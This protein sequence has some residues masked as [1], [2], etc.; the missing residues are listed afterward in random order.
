[1]E[2]PM[3]INPQM[4]E[5]INFAMQQ[6][7][8]PVFRSLTLTNNTEDPLK[9]IK[10]SITFEPEF[11]KPWETSVDLLESGKPVEISPVRIVMLSEYLYSLTEK[12]S[13]NVHIQAK[14]GD[15]TVF[16]EDKSIELYACDQWL[17]IHILPEMTAAFITPNHPKISEITA[18]ASMY[19]NKW[20]GDPSFTG[21]QT[22][23]PNIVKKQAAA[24]YAALQ[25]ENIAYTMPPASY[26]IRGQRV[27]L[28]YDVLEQKCGTCIDLS[29]LFAACCENVGLSPLIIFLKNHAFA[30]VWLEDETFSE[31]CEDDLA[32]LTKRTADGINALCLIECTDFTAGRSVEFDLSVKHAN[33]N[34]HDADKFEF[35]LDIVRC[36]VSGIRPMPV[37]IMQN[38]VFTSIDH[39]ERGQNDITNAPKDLG[40]TFEIKEG[41]KEITRQDIWER[42]L[43]DINLKNNLL[44]FRPSSSNI[45]FMT[46]SLSDLEDHI[47]C[48]EDLK[49]MPAPQEMTLQISDSK[50]FEIE[51]EKDLITSIADAE[52]KNKRLRTFISPAELDRILKKLHRQAK[53]SLEENGANTLYL[54]LGLLRWY[55][56]PRSERPRYAPIVLIPVDMI[57]KV[58]DRSYS[59]RIRDEE[60]QIN[61]TLL[62]M[63]RQ[64]FGINISGLDPLPLDES[65]VDLPMIFSTIRSCVMPQKRWDIVETAFL[66]QFSFSHFIM[67]ND[68]RSR[69]KE[70]AQNK[71]VASIISGKLEWQPKNIEMTCAQMDEEISPADMAVPMSVDSS[72][73]AAIYAAAQGESFVLHGPPGTGKSQTITNMIANALYNGKTVL[74]VAEK[75]AALSVVQKRLASIGIDPFCLELH[76]NKTQK[77]AVLG[78]LEQALAAGRIKAPEDHERTAA[79]LYKL[80]KELN[81]VMTRIHRVS[82]IGMSLYDAVVRYDALVEHKS[83]IIIP[84]QN[85]SQLDKYK[86][87][88]ILDILKNISAVGRECGGYKNSP[89]KNY[90]RKDHSPEIKDNFEKITKEFLNIIPQI[91]SYFSELSTYFDTSFSQYYDD[92]FAAVKILSSAANGEYFAQAIS[93]QNIFSLKNEIDQ[94]LDSGKKFAAISEEISKDFEDTVFNIDAVQLKLEWKRCEQKWLIPK[95][96]GKKKIVKE[97]NIHSCENGTVT[98]DNFLQICGKLENYAKLKE[99]INC[100]DE[101]IISIFG[102]MWQ[103]ENSQFELIEKNILRS[104][105]IKNMLDTL[106]H[107]REEIMIALISMADNADKKAEISKKL[108]EYYPVYTNLENILDELENKY[109]I[110]LENIKNSQCWFDTAQKEADGWIDSIAF[111][112]ERSTLENLI[113]ELKELAPE[114]AQAYISGQ[115]TEEDILPAFEFA[116]SS[117]FISDVFANDP[118]LA[119]FQSTSFDGKLEK[120]RELTER[121]RQLTINELAA[122]LSAKIPDASTETSSST[123][124]LSLLRKAVKNGGR[125][126]PI[127]KLFDSIPNLLR[128]ICP[129]MLMSPI[130]VAQYIDPSFPKF[131][132]VIFDEASQMPTA[133]AVGAIARG[134]NVIVVGDPKQMPPTSFFASNQVDEENYDKE[135]LESVLD[136]CLAL[137][138]PERHLLWHYRSRHESL[139]AFSN[140]KFYGNDLLTFP[141]PSDNISEVKWVNVDGYYDKGKTKQNRAEAAAIVSEIVRRLKD[142]RLRQESIGVVTFSL[143]QQNLIDDMLSE[144]FV[145]DPQLE[146]YADE[147]YEPIFIKNLENVQGDERDVILFSIGYGPDENG[148]VSMN[149]GPLNRDGGWRRLNVAVSRARKEMIV[150]SVIRPEQIDLSRTRSDGVA[151]LRS[152]IEYAAKGKTALAVNS[153]NRSGYS[154]G[155]AKAIAEELRKHGCK[156][157]CGIGC[158]G[159]K[160]DVGIFDPEDPSRYLLALMCDSRS[161]IDN[162]TSRDRNIVQ[163]EILKGLG[164]NICNVHILDWL[165][166]K[167]RVIEKI[168]SAINEAS[169]KRKNSSAEIIPETAVKNAPIIFEHTEAPTDRPKGEIYV[170]CELPVMGTAEK[171]YEPTELNKI[172]DCIKK[173]VN[174]EAPISS[175]NVE[176]KIISAWGISRSGSRVSKVIENA[177]RICGIKTTV[178]N[179]SVFL[180]ADGQEPDEYHGCRI[181]YD[182]QKRSMDDICA[183]EICEGIMIILRAQIGMSK[184]DLIRE[185]AK[186]FGFTR[187]GG[188]IESSVNSG[189]DHAVKNGLI[190]IDD[191]DKITIREQ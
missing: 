119:S 3:T 115:V 101:N 112:R 14:C 57:R 15:E 68:I 145:K 136:D 63:L 38:G 188:V 156:A 86:Y 93:S 12:I 28:P 165:N 60:T 66:G 109:F 26:E 105:E 142:E 128:R 71:V 98:Q 21:Y 9:D 185:T 90:H 118:E 99:K 148:K 39:G 37:R 27:R 95:I 174:K 77:K 184:S 173:V 87:E 113:C 48:G 17:G 20:T 163:P 132:L 4:T 151:Y 139:I 141:S 53:V 172:I 171:F 134:E 33:H 164:W 144:E 29:L 83:K 44:N 111:L 18:K 138:M 11:A 129:C 180:W 56:T 158:S 69:S 179:S 85:I 182:G 154:D 191:N 74:F 55:E 7:Y 159:Y 143:V 122:R 22:K 155:F 52:F 79:K 94:L 70:L 114:A 181:H 10:I 65:G 92:Y 73:L 131:D 187:I 190:D 167:Q 102:R 31:P 25:A 162:S 54:A 130:S 100:A 59:L 61:I 183:Q 120:Y 89:L 127:R 5:K 178:S 45:Q 72:Q 110:D 41:T 121:F 137:A 124:E 36:R 88:N 91:R 6:N 157:E 75:M 30:G 117:A 46:A 76:S 58:Q 81:S 107:G 147:N 96:L 84:A 116:A 35:A 50:I 106:S 123:S 126:L 2:Y 49:I 170:Y 135:D 1:M 153:E 175:K 149:F 125:M 133:E 16:A 146:I 177:V 169:Q 97:M 67:W 168:I 176:K 40:R 24:L 23:N 80:R 19:L 152:F 42:K 161:S 64:N 13:G 150:Y 8:I 103:K 82:S 108:A 32:A 160:I 78:Q 189:I 140:A 186:L 34:L 62:E 104:F 43:L 51:N 166:N 47:A